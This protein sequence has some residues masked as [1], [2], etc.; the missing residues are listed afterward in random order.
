MQIQRNWVVTSRGG[1]CGGDRN[2][3]YLGVGRA[4]VCKGLEVCRFVASGEVAA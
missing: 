1:D 2:V 4:A 3:S